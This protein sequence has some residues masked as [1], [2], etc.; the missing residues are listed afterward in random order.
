M[1]IKAMGSAYEGGWDGFAKWPGFRG[2]AR[3]LGS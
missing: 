2:L 3:Q 1:F